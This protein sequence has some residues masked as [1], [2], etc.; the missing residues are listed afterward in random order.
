MTEIRVERR[1][2][3]WPWI[4][5]VIL[6]AG[7]AWVVIAGVGDN[8]PGAE[9]AVMDRPAE[10]TGQGEGVGTSGRIPA[11]IQ[12]YSAFVEDRSELTPGVEHDYTAEGIRRLS[13]ALGA[14]VEQRANDAE[15]RTR[16]ERFRETADRLQKDP[17]S[18]AHAG[19]V[20]DVF[21]SAAD[22][23]ESA[24]IDAGD[25]SGLR[26]TASALSTERQLLDQIDQVKQFFR[27]SA[28]A[29]ERA[30]AKS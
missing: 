7:L 18:G 19:M 30:T 14:Y 3:V 2:P 25:V 9:Q 1:S 5:G 26:E 20:R 4:L 28:D 12:E 11:A 10:G 16:F 22:V 17:R 24:R 13:A 27:Q 21:T 23:F 6:L 29:L 15:T 8:E